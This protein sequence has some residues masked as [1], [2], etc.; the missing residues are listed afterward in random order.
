MSAAAEQLSDAQ[1]DEVQPLWAELL[2]HHSALPWPPG[3]RPRPLEASWADRRE[4][5][6][7][8]MAEG[9][10]ALFVVRDDAGR[11][12]GF[13]AVVLHDGERPLL[14]SETERVG[15]LDTIVVSEAAR[16]SGAGTVLVSAARAWLRERDAAPM[17]IS[18]RAHN[19]A[20]LAFYAGLGA[21]QAFVTLALP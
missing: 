12:T 8:G 15:E 2:A 1:L 19:D 9:T 14:Q 20:A 17:L 5:Y 13:A 18:V 7:R 3:M 11:P 21:T 4:R 10:A 16:G 6:A